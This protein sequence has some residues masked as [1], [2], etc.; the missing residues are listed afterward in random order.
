MKEIVRKEFDLILEALR[1]EIETIELYNTPQI[2]E[3]RAVILNRIVN[4]QIIGMRNIIEDTIEYFGYILE[5]INPNNTD[6]R[7]YQNYFNITTKILLEFNE[8]W[9]LK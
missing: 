8:K 3:E 2:S 6:F 4:Y 9:S 7:E 5:F 1:Y